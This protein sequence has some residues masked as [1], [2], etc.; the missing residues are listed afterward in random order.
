MLIP[1]KALFKA[2]GIFLTA[3]LLLLA[4]RLFSN[5]ETELISQ[6]WWLALGALILISALDALMIIRGAK[7]EC[8]RQLPGHLALGAKGKIALKFQNPSARPLLFDYTDSI[9][10]SVTTS[11]LPAELLLP[12]GEA[13][14]IEYRVKPIR[15]GIATFGAVIMRVQSPFHLW[16]FQSKTEIPQTTKI[17]PN[18]MAIANLNFLGAEQKLAH[19]GAHLSQ[20]RG[21]GMSFKQLREYQRGDEIR[22]IDWKATSRMHKLISRE[23]QDERDQE[24][25]FLL[26]SGRRMRAM[27]GELSHFDHSINALLLTAYIALSGGDAVGFMN[28]GSTP[29]WIKPVK[30]RNRINT[31]LN[32]LYDLHSSTDACDLPQSAELL[33]A[34]QQKR[35][36]IVLITNVRD[37]DS[38]D[39]LLAVRLLSKRHLVMIACLQEKCL[40]DQHEV[41]TLDDALTYSATQL[42]N[43]QRQ[44]LITRLRSQGVIIADATPDLMHVALVNAYMQ[45]KRAGRI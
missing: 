43:S 25:I 10:D 29:R 24:I 4:L 2:L 26:D 28:M 21:S 9:P 17:Y 8:F 40:G 22:Q 39:L 20:R 41:E 5:L 1:D 7:P 31:L 32:N 38:D 34:R 44:Q 27:D 12:P 14:I 23:Y 19:I 11:S 6:L 37:E 3:A 16:R 35:S 36:L 42:Y 18:F 13:R 30:G 45:L 15:R 33:L